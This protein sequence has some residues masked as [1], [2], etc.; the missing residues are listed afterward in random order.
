MNKYEYILIKKIIQFI[1]T[2]YKMWGDSEAYIEPNGLGWSYKTFD[3][4]EN[5]CID[6]NR[7]IETGKI[8]IS[9]NDYSVSMSVQD[10]DST[11]WYVAKFPSWNDYIYYV[12]KSDPTSI[13]Y[14]NWDDLMMSVEC[15][16]DGDNTTYDVR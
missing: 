10:Y 8:T 6:K 4:D 9:P 13:F 16:V 3:L 7:I 14:A 15:R 2:Y 1:K 11:E 12:Q 5:L